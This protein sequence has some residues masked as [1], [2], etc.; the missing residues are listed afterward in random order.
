MAD[1]DQTANINGQPIS[2][3]TNWAK[4]P[5]LATLKGDVEAAKPAQKEHM[6]R[7]QQWLDNLHIRGKAAIKAKKGRSS[8]QP[9]LIRKSAE[10]RYSPLTEPFLAADKLFTVSPTTWEDK[11]SAEQNE[12]VLNWQ[13]RTK[14]NAIA[15]IDEFVRTDVDEGTVAV[16]VG[17]RRELKKVKEQAPVY[18]YYPV[19]DKNQAQALQEAMQLEDTNP[20]V[21]LD[22][23]A[24]IIESVHYS[25]SA[26]QLFIAQQTGTQEV[27]VEK[28]IR[29]EPTVRVIN[30]DNLVVDATCGSNVDD[31]MFMAYSDEI[32]RGD[33]RS[34][35]RFKNLDAVDWGTT[36]LAEPDHTPRGPAE[37]NF[38]DESRQKVV[39]N[40]WYGL[41]DIDGDGSLTPIYVAWVGNVM[42]RCELNP[43]PDGKPPFV[44]VPYMPQKRSFYGEP[45]GELLA[46]SQKILGAVVR[47]IIDTMARSANGQRGMAK[48]ML[49]VVNQRRFEAGDDY[50]FNPSVHPAN[51]VID[52]TYPEIPSSA[53]G[54]IQLQNS[55]A[56][57]LTG[58]KNFSGDGI[59]GNSYGSIATGAKGAMTAAATREMSILRR[60]A[61]G[62]IQI[63]TK[64]IAMNQE[65]L[66]EEEVI[67]VTN[68]K[69]VT[70]RREDLKGSF[71]LKVTI[72]TTEED[73]AKAQEL[74]FMLQTAAQSMDGGERQLVMA[75]IARLRRMPEL[76]HAIKNY[77]P[78]PDP[79]QQQIQQLQLQK[80][81]REVQL[82]EAKISETQAQGQLEMAEARAIGAKA[83][84]TNLDYVEQ[85]TGT[86]HARRMDELSQQSDANQ[87]LAITK[88]ILDQRPQGAHNPD[89]KT[90][91]A[92]TRDNLLEA[93]QFHQ[94]TKTPPPNPMQ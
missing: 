63:G 82:L 64:I 36:V 18:S 51:G 17:W 72:S 23:P 59:N 46:D 7:V 84:K 13:F 44:I 86:T 47:G 45:D 50:Q 89:D 24:N 38:K 61:K 58:V 88:G 73:N 94:L 2:R 12:L 93:F 22:L 90:P 67:R 20:N 56:E 53:M 75:E 42:V 70:V 79:V 78:E 5:D 76:A 54:M 92:P 81:Q 31:A 33:L 37:V 16:R 30:M 77:K 57:S 28:V 68:E 8:V 15:F 1:N 48:N 14:I 34:D 85:Q 39:L 19:F 29:N 66:S 60:L 41:Y 65:F 83:D 80:L 55:E 32:T 87:N 4:E 91:D 11:A 62:V 74:A 3:L 27:E 25:K 35:G 52:H 49:D 71:D 69:F 26:G 43:Y 40:E 9:R 6:S 21:F 10:W